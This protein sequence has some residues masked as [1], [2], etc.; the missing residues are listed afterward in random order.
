[1]APK[2]KL[3]Y[4]DIKALAEPIRFLFHYGK[5]D[6][7][8][9]RYSF[10]EWKNELKP[11]APFGQGPLLEIDGDPKKRLWQ[12]VAIQRYIASLVGLRG[13]D[14]W[15][16][17]EV[18]MM[19]ETL[20]DLRCLL[21][22]WYTDKTENKD[23]VKDKVLNQDLPFFLQRLDKRVA[24]HKGHFVNGKVTWPDLQY[25]AMYEY[26]SRMAGKGIDDEYP[27]LKS[28]RQKISEIPQ[29]KSWMEKR[30]PSEW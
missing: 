29:I 8:D 16:K 14:D 19:A 13:S 9:Y 11:T 30:P 1:M 5:I 24:E 18:D 22:L 12:S 26:L 27:N 3:M 21:Y 20:W 28:L 2:Y 7:E 10:E 17:F 15:E 4:F 25:T 6:F 23:K